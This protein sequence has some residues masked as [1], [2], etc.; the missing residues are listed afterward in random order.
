MLP[1]EK[2]ESTKRYV[3]GMRSQM[4]HFTRHTVWDQKKKGEK[5]KQAKVPRQNLEPQNIASYDKIQDEVKNFKEKFYP[6]RLWVSN[7]SHKSS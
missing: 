1:L 3:E 7:A 6:G 2:Q 4:C 5:N